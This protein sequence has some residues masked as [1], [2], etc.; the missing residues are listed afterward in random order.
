LLSILGPPQNRGSNR[1]DTIIS[2]SPLS[3]AVNA[4]RHEPITAETVR[5]AADEANELISY[6]NH[7]TLSW[8]ARVALPLPADT[9]RLIGALHQI[10]Q[11]MHQTL[12][13]AA[14]RIAVVGHGSEESRLALMRLR[15]ARETLQDV[16]GQ[17]GQAHAAAAQVSG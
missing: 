1:K 10:A 9:T 2:D 7:A 8:S 11:H 15:S 12:G 3:A 17:L 6:L 5:L 4:L 16:T 13:H 14:E